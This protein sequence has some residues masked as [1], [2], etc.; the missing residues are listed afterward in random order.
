MCRGTASR[1]TGVWR[2]A[3]TA[4][5]VTGVWRHAWTASRVTGVWRHAWTALVPS[6]LSA[7]TDSG[8]LSPGSQ[9]C[10]PLEMSRTRSGG[11]PSLQLAVGVWLHSRQ[12]TS[13]RSMAS[14]PSNPFR[15][16]VQSCDDMKSL[17]RR[18]FGLFIEY[19][20]FVLPYTIFQAD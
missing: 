18:A 6:L 11:R 7:P 14:R 13:S 4:S 12:S 15:F 1:V 5:R 8:L 2:H 19:R 16:S 20:G 9:V 17:Y 3:W 10:L